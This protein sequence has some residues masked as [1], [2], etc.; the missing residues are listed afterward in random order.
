MIEQS[1]NPPATCAH[2]WFGNLPDSW[3]VQRLRHACTSITDGSH[4]S[5]ASTSEGMPYVTVS[6]L[7]GRTVAVDRAVRIS[8]EDFARMERDGCRPSVGDV[9]FSKDGTVGKVAVVHR[10][11]FVVLSSLAIL[12]PRRH[13]DSTFLA[14]RQRPAPGWDRLPMLGAA[15]DADGRRLFTLSARF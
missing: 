4:F 8:P 7:V 12:R 14:Q 3:D 15:I 11:D 10:D 13:L 2:E 9:L 1:A 6:D 5:P